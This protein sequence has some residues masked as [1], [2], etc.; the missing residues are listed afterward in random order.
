DDRRGLMLDDVRNRPDNDQAL[1]STRCRR[2]HAV[3]RV[4]I[5]DT[6]N[7]IRVGSVRLLS[8]TGARARRA[9]RTPTTYTHRRPLRSLARTRGRY[10][11]A[12]LPRTTKWRDATSRRTPCQEGVILQITCSGLRQCCPLFWESDSR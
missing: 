10:I 6:T 4:R 7:L 11:V 1:V 9:E 12:G 3:V 8:A 2:H 5:G